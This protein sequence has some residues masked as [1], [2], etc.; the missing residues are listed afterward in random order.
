MTG[1]ALCLAAAVA[2]AGVAR[3]QPRPAAAQP[4]RQK[5]AQQAASTDT[6]FTRWDKDKN[7]VLSREEFNAGWKQLE[8]NLALRKLHANFVAMD[9]NKDGSL[10]ASE[11]ANLPLIKKAGTS[12][13]PM[14]TFDADKNQHLDF[15]EYIGMVNSMLK[16][17]N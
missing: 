16:K 10:D 13:P 11:Y 4:T 8:V 2:M 12:A 5:Q 15:K 14:S 3:A 6:M 9:A 7:N 1:Y 17:K